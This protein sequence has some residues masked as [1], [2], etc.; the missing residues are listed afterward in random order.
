MSDNVIA[1]KRPSAQEKH[2]GKTL[3]RSG[4]HK[5]KVV[6]ERKFDVK[7]GKLV[8]LYECTRCKAQKSTAH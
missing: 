3:C 6:T 2:K 8:T 7:Q 1:F 4:F 5:W